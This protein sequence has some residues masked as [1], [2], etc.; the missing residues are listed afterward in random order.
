MRRFRQLVAKKQQE[1]GGKTWDVGVVFSGGNTTMKAIA[2]LFGEENRKEAE[3]EE[4]KL[5]ME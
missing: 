3:R 1:Q 5:G 4:G 2:G